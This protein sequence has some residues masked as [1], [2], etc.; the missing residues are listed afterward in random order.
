[1]RNDCPIRPDTMEGGQRIRNQIPRGLKG[2]SATPPTKT[3]QNLLQGLPLWR[4]DPMGHD[5]KNQ[6]GSTG[7]LTPPGF[8]RNTC[9]KSKNIQFNVQGY[10]V[11]VKECLWK[12]Y[13][14]SIEYLRI[15]N[16]CLRILRIPHC[17]LLFSNSPHDF[18]S[19]CFRALV[20]E[21]WF[22]NFR[23][24]TLVSELSFQS[25]R[26]RTLVSEL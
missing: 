10:P 19:F 5:S 11:N 16:E 15:S 14:I 2:A 20:S 4:G 3:E 23:F 7:G 8:N 6:A 21:L 9:S 1:M 25:F 13:K 22:Q 18:Q 12:F 26:F 17:S 24:R